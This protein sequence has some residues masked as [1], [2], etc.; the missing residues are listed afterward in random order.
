M[1][2]FILD[3]KFSQDDLKT[4]KLFCRLYY[5]NLHDFGSYFCYYLHI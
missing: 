4:Y 2:A 1:P 5:Y 3:Y